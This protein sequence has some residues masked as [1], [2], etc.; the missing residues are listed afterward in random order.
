MSDYLTHGRIAGGVVSTPDL[1][2][3]LADYHGCLGLAVVEQGTLDAGLAA[4]WGC[5]KSAGARF[6]TLQPQSGAHCFVRLVEAPLP[7]DFKPTRTF[8]WAAYELT[9]KDVFGWPDR[10]QGSGFDIVGPPKALEGLPY[11]IP[12][13]VTGR[14]REMIYL[15]E[16]A[17][18]TPTSDLPKANSLTDHIFIVILATP[19]REA[20]LK[21]FEQALKLD[22][23]SSYT[24][25]YSMINNAFGLGSDY[26]TTITM[27]Q[28]GR[29]PIIEVDDYPAEAAVRQGDPEMLPP[30]NAM[31][32]LAIDDL[33][34][35]D[36]AFIAPPVERDGPVYEG[37]RA[38]T[39]RGY[40]GELIELIEIGG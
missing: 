15:N 10:L 31:I 25:A 26:R 13:Q 4:S 12:M 28:K 35:L 36:V 38:A 5:P 21:W 22:V 20:S 17:D 6:A 11:F 40:A 3:A 39:V 34:A 16:V 33:D 32:T 18:N 9:V 30:G 14:G 24:L 1:D 37:R 23:S 27:V 2:A 19:D 29:L 8:G 7:D